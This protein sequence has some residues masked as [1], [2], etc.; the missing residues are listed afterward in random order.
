[1]AIIDSEGRLSIGMEAG[2]RLG[3]LPNQRVSFIWV[4]DKTYRL[5]D[6]NDK[7]KGEAIVAGEFPLID[8]KYRFFVPKTIRKTYTREA[9]V[10]EKDGTL[11]VRFFRLRSDEEWLRKQL[12]VSVTD[13][14]K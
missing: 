11:Y 9:I 4:D 13:D 2:E 5:G 8:E 10:L 6:P 12:L 3:Y 1:M 14:R 7:I